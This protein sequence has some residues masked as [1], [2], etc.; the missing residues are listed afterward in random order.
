MP[1][2]NFARRAW[3]PLMREARLVTTKIVEGRVQDVPNYTPY[4]L[5]HYF[6]SRLIAKGKDLKF[7]QV[8]MGHADIQTTLNIYGHL[9]KDRD[10][11]HI[12]TAEEMASELVLS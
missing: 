3:L 11:E 5:R 12:K 10:S 2:N 1:L 9:L 7:I 8:T 4:A 6:A